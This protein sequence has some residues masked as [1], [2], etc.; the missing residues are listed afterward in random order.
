[1]LNEAMIFLPLFLVVLWPERQV[2]EEQAG[3]STSGAT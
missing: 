3:G 2:G 1:M